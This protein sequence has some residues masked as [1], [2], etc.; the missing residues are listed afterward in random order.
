MRVLAATGDPIAELAALMDTEKA[1]GVYERIRASGPVTVSR[2]LVRE[3]VQW[4]QYSAYLSS[5]Q[6]ANVKARIS[7]LIVTTS[8]SLSN[9]I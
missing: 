1:Y 6:M 9:S 7:G 8:R 5:P 3:V 4:D 2:P